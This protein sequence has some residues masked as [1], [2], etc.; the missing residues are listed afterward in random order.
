MAARRRAALEGARRLVRL[1]GAKAAVA[2]M[3][4]SAEDGRIKLFVTAQTL[5]LRRRSQE[6]FEGGYE[7]VRLTGEH[8][9]CGCA[10]LRGGED[11]L[12]VAGCI[13]GVRLTRGQME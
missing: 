11:R 6:V 1:H 12:L 13:R 8:A 2:E 9:D 5:A 4:A 7:A 3:L 10:Y